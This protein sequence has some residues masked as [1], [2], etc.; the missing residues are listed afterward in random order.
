VTAPACFVRGCGHPA[1]V[2]DLDGATPFCPRH[3]HVAWAG[4]VP[5]AGAEDDTAVRWC[6]GIPPSPG[7]QTDAPLIV[8]R[9]G[10]PRLCVSCHAARLGR[11][12]FRP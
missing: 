4:T 10:G 11:E 3:A 8:V 1:T 2:R 7:H 5:V 12:R 9:P 6:L